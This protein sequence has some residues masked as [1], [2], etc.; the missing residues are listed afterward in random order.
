MIVDTE[1]IE[2]VLTGFAPFW[3]EH[4]ERALFLS[5]CCFTHREES[6]IQLLEKYRTAPTP[7]QNKAQYKEAGLYVS[8][9]IDRLIPGL[10]DVFNQW[11]ETDFSNHFWRIATITWLNAFVSACYDFWE[12]IRL[13]QEL[14]E[15]P[16]IRIRIL[17]DPVPYKVLDYPHFSQVITTHEYNIHL[18]S[19]MMRLAEFSGIQCAEEG[20]RVKISEPERKIKH[21]GSLRERMSSR[22]A[23][24]IHRAGRFC[25]SRWLQSDIHF[26]SVKGLPRRDRIRLR[27]LR[28]RK[29]IP[30]MDACPILPKAEPAE[31]LVREMGFSPKTDFESMMPEML[32]KNIPR[33]LLTGIPAL[34]G[35]EQVRF[36]IGNDVL[37]SQTEAFKIARV[38]ESGGT[39]ISVQHG[40]GYGQSLLQ[41]L[42]KIEIETSKNFISWGWNQSDNFKGWVLPMSSPYLS[43]IRKKERRGSKIILVGTMRPLYCHRFDSNLTTEDAGSYLKHKLS[44]ISGLSNIM[45]KRLYYKPYFDDYGTH[46]KKM[47][48]SILGTD[49]ILDAKQRVTKYISFDNLLIVDHPGTVLLEAAAVNMP[50]I[51]FFSP[52]IFPPSSTMAVYLHSLRKAGVYHE[53][54][55]AAAGH[56]EK[57]G[58]DIRSWW[59]SHDVHAAVESFRQEYARASSAYFDE[60]AAFVREQ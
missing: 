26:G 4:P 39:W 24:W 59:Y 14:P 15:N 56:C 37:H 55:E 34:E 9:L 60:W 42:E 31:F 8:D 10:T 48:A 41:T 54:P 33:R 38:V 30:K 32:L 3:P 50:F 47:V 19:Q 5:P 2:L 49:H 13:I 12:R 52:E 23:G 17:K 53:T 35:C 20:V 58:M 22:A 11:Y 1:R 44:F 16:D 18:F 25:Y 40:A 6:M 29:H 7:W 57:I 36:W 45:K 43:R 21:T 28:R 51:F 27:M 46:E